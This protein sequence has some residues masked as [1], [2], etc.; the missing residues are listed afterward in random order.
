MGDTQPDEHKPQT[1][2]VRESTGLVKSVS[3]L[4]SITLNFSNMSVGPLLTTIA[5][6]TVATMVLV[7]VS[8]LNL[9]MA[10]V[11]AFLLSIP[12][13]AVYTMMSRRFPRAGGDYIWLS[14]TFGGFAGS[15]LSFWGYV[16][17][18]LAFIALVVILLDYAI[19]GVGATM[20]FNYGF[21]TTSWVDLFNPGFWQF[22]VGAVAFSLV[23]LLNVLKPKAGY[24]FVTVLA[25]FG[26][27]TLIVGMAV[28]LGGG[29]A[30]LQNYT[31]CAGAYAGGTN[32]LGLN[33][34]SSYSTVA[35]TYQPSGMPFDLNWGN[36]I[37]IMPVMFAFI[38]PW[39]NAAPAVASEIKGKTAL[40]WNVP[41]SAVLSFAFLTS[42]F[43]VLYA[44]GGVPFINGVFHDLAYQSIGVNFFS[45]AMGV[46]NNAWVAWIIGLG[47][48]AL[49]F[50]VIAYAT[51]VFSRYML[52]QS[53][54]RFLPSKLAYVSPRFGSP[55]VAYALDWVITIILVAITAYYFGS[56]AGIFGAIIAAM[57]YFMF[58]GLAAVVHA[59]RKETGASKAVLM[60]AGVL[61]ILV[62]GFVAYQ[63]LA[64]PGFTGLNELTAVYSIGT[65]VVGALIYLVSRW[66]HMKRGMNIDLNY[67]EL[68]PE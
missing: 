38:Y 52:A 15:T 30:G 28:L 36:I 19:G 50:A 32:C 13:I 17:E 8:G 66:Y 60:L 3:F 57:I 11:I 27:F 56:I 42:T 51:I 25:V 35:A 47:W 65:L 68:P 67:R 7:N 21:P 61:N 63:F 10:S 53:M 29:S 4:D 20:G 43:A 54:D 16:M 18:T 2:F 14:R 23:I 34:T 33:G 62:F 59:A 9:V 6:S 31:N 24:K 45:L 26:A 44:V 58:V 55:M 40:K 41:I 48:I 1:V 39:L 5:G 37:Y 46:S 64:N 12:Q 49:Q 22:A